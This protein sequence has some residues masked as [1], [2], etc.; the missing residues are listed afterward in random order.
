MSQ[1]QLLRRMLRRIYGP[2]NSKGIWRITWNH[3]IYELYEEPKISTNIK[4]MRL[5]WARHVQGAKKSSLRVW[6]ERDRW[7]RWEDNISKDKRD[8]LG[9]K[10]WREQ[11][12]D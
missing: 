10:N 5:Q 12:R 11:P 8:L 1:A 3:E 9:I 2:V 6:E 4:L 7:A